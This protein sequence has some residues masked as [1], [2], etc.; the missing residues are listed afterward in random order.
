MTNEERTFYLLTP[1]STTARRTITKYV[2]E[3]AVCEYRKPSAKNNKQPPKSKTKNKHTQ[4]NLRCK[5]FAK[6][7]EVLMP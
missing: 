6:M 2:E 1:C 5:E 3:K 7:D 4:N